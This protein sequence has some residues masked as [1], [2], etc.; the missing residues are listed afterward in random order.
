MSAAAT[1][2]AAVLG[3]AGPKP[4]Q[5][6]LDLARALEEGLPVDAVGRVSRLVAPDDPAFRDRLA[7]RATLACRRHREHLTL[8]EGER[9][10]RIARTEAGAR[11]VEQML[12]RL[13]FGTAA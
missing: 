6:Q 9:V 7:A 4:I 10:E 13:E 11:A 2:I 12:E 8:E 1:D 5:G 3:L